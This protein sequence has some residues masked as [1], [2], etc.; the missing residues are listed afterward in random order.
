MNLSLDNNVNKFVLLVVVGV[1][2]LLA[3]NMNKIQL[4]NQVST[5]ISVLVIVA[6]GYFGYTLLNQENE[7]FKVNAYETDAPG[8]NYEPFDNYEHFQDNGEAEEAA[9]AAEAEAANA[10][11]EAL[12]NAEADNAEAEAEA[13]ANAANVEVGPQANNVGAANAQTFNAQEL[14][15][16]G[17]GTWAETTPSGPGALTTGSLLNA[18][19]HVG[20]NT[21][22]C[23]MRN[24][25]RGLRS[26]PANPQAQVSPW[27][28]STICPDLYRK[29]LDCPN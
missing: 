11:A 6:C 3:V 23:S 29:P 28:Q 14:L 7:T 16:G 12:A 8:A 25:N 5:L 22:G 18:G 21:V 19:H 10:E 26:E 20:V 15:P 13:L 27:Q 17:N 4:G 1:V 24:A 9:L 2:I